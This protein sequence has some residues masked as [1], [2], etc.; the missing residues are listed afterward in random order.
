M[1]WPTS[2]VFILAV[3]HLSSLS[4]AYILFHNIDPGGEVFGTN[5]RDQNSIQTQEFLKHNC[6]KYC[7]RYIAPFSACIDVAITT[8]ITKN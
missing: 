2:N 6:S 1:L 7:I 3:E 5:L 4:Q 8:M